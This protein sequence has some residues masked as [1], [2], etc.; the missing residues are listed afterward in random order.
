VLLVQLE[1]SGDVGVVQGGGGLCF[2]HEPLAELR[3]L[4]GMSG[5]ELQRNASLELEVFDFV[6]HPPPA[7]PD[8]LEDLAVPVL[9]AARKG[10]I[11]GGFGRS[12]G[13]SVPLTSG[14]A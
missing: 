1:D 6:D 2:A 11:F 13:A 5:K 3:V 4:H 7:L 14:P 12:Q 10:A 8:L 9:G